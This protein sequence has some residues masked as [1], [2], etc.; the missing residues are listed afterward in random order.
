M[1]KTATAPPPPPPPPEKYLALPVGS[2]RTREEFLAASLTFPFSLFD[3]QPDLD[4]G[5]VPKIEQEEGFDVPGE[6][7]GLYKG[8]FVPVF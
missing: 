8:S 5:K 2:L 3:Q 4:L 7:P 1:E 6:A